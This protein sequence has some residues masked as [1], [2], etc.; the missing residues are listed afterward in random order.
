MI[1]LHNVSFGYNTQ[2]VIHDISLEIG[3]GWTSIVGPNGSGKSTLIHLMNGRF[4][5]TK[6][7]I[8]LNDKE[9]HTYKPIERA[10]LM[11]TIH[12]EAEGQFPI[13]CFDR[14]SFGR[15]PWQTK[16]EGLTDYD[17]QVIYE[18]MNATKTLIHKDHGM[19]ELSGGEKQRVILA[20]ALAQE[21]EI[22]LID[23][24][25]SALD[26]RH[27]REMI[28]CI[29][30]RIVKKGMKVVAIIH[31]LNMAYQVSDQV[32]MLKD[33]RVISHGT[34][35]AAMTTSLVESVYDTKVH[36]DPTYGFAINY[37]L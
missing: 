7:K 12:Q 20:A 36:Y 2:Q 23:E 33:G 32:I 3:E 13:S 4:K 17:Y 11:A 6:G 14:V 21:P 15:Y 28:G 31:D 25:F 19:H 29:K 24:G 8:T 30:E 9:I 10:R 18:S 27:K 34:T 35:E 22:L 5:P 1:G 26:I 16:V 37:K